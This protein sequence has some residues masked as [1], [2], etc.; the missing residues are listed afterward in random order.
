MLIGFCLFVLFVLTVFSMVLGSVLPG[1]TV[2][3]EYE[4]WAIIN[5]TRQTMESSSGEGFFFIDPIFGAI[6]I[7]IVITIIVALLG[8]QIFGS[9]LSEASVKII[10]SALLYGGLW[11]LLS[12][13]SMPLIVSIEMFGTL[14]YVSLTIGYVYGVIKQMMGGGGSV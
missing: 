4:T 10:T 7:L 14:I 13:V 2:G 12:V 11:G 3:A 6:G 5:G 1:S 8:I 9:G